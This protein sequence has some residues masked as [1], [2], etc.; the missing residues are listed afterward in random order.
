M[1]V[2]FDRC[3]KAGEATLPCDPQLDWPIGMGPDSVMLR[4][5]DLPMLEKQQDIR[6]PALFQLTGT[7][8][9]HRF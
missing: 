7:R 9:A 2:D 5:H 1:I 6:M 8:H 4:E 3:G